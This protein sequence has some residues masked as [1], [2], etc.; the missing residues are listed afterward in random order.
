MQ[1]RRSTKQIA[2]FFII[3]FAL[4]CS[5]I[6]S[7]AAFKPSFQKEQPAEISSAFSKEIQIQDEKQK[8]KATENEG[9]W[10]PSKTFIITAISIGS[11]LDIIIAILWA[12]HENKKNQ[13]SQ[14]YNPNKWTNKKWFWYLV[15]M[16]IVLPKNGKLTISWKNLFLTIL[17]LVLLKFWFFEKL[18]SI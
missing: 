3:Y 2:L 7:A 5:L 11:V 14:S 6:F 13:E 9:K 4:L 8:R 1:M 10:Q 15:S 16:G 12:R 18:E 17:F